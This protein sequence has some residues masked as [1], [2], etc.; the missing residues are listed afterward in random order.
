MKALEWAAGRGG[1]LFPASLA[2]GLALPP[3]AGLIRPHLSLIVLALTFTILLRIDLAAVARELRRPGP[4]LA[5]S[6]VVLLASPPLVWAVSRAIGLDAGLAAALVVTAC[7][8]PITSAPAFARIMG[9]D[10][11]LALA[12]AVA[13]MVATPLTAP[14]LALAFAG[15]DL[16]LSVQAMAARLGL[17][18]GL[19]LAAS[20]LAR[21]LAAGALDR[22]ARGIEGA[23]VLL[24]SLFATGVMDGVTALALGQPGRAATMLAAAFALNAALFALG[25]ALFAA[26][27]MQRRLTAGLLVGNRQMA[28]MLAVLPDAA[29]DDVTLFLAVAQLPLYLNPFMLRPLLRR[30]LGGS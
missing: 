26:A 25:A 6:A 16:A 7:A 13:G 1:S 30:L 28:L 12:A 17:F 22:H 23:T 18:I 9:L 24:L 29:P 2:L 15:L 10:A 4:V 20:I 3:L 14:P 19:P 21:R 11:G 8:P 5:V 27:G